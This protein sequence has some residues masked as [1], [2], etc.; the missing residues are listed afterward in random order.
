MA[1]PHRSRRT[2]RRITGCL[3]FALLTSLPL[4]L[5]AADLRQKSEA[6]DRDPQWNAHNNQVKVEKPNPVVQDFGYSET[7][8]AGGKGKGELGGRVQRCTTPAFYG[9]RF[10]K[11]RT[12]GQKLRCSGTFAVTHTMGMSSLYF[13]WF[14]SQTME[15]RP[16][17]YLGM[18][19]NGE[20]RGCEV[21]LSYNTT[22][23]Q[24]DGFRA[25]GTGP[26]GVA[27]RNFNLIPTDTPY[28]WELVYDPAA[29]D[30]VG[31]I[32]F[33]LGGK[34]P[35]TG[36]PFVHKLSPQQRKAGAT[37]DSFGIVNPQ[38]AGNW[39][40]FYVDDLMIDGETES[41]DRDPN[42]VG[43]GN[44][45][46]LDDYGEEGAHQFGYADSARAGGK[47]GE[48]GGVMFS[49]P[50]SPGY[51]GDE[52]GRLTLDDPLTASG[53]VV[54][55][56][57]GPDGGLYLGW[58]DSRKRGYPPANILGVLIDGTTSG[59]PRFRG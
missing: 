59:G 42:W 27:V 15:V 3:L 57:Y 35:F 31:A 56:Q 7:N 36:G 28:T 30:G 50:S 25:T 41:F 10:E 46:Q 23:G 21:H 26:K 18:M 52:V 55:P 47:K 1:L 5:L 14:N 40:T 39:L 12:L 45:D 34:G 9:R 22:A 2:L 19:I 20:G 49:S 51:Y 24:S 16:R 54:L 48:I 17:N 44:R 11:A 13:G 8:H 33:T 32:T 37:F 58:F 29:N 53:K 43:Q 38:S 4:P 6:F